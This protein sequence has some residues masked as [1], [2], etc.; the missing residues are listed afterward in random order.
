MGACAGKSSRSAVVTVK[1]RPN[2]VNPSLAEHQAAFEEY[3]DH[4]KNIQEN[5]PI[6]QQQPQNPQPQAQSI[7][8]QPNYSP[9][10]DD[11]PQHISQEKQV[12][13]PTRHTE[14]HER[15]PGIEDVNEDDFAS[16][17]NK[18]ESPQAQNKAKVV[19][20]Y[21]Q[22][23][24]NFALNFPGNQVHQEYRET[25]HNEETKTYES[26]NKDKKMR[27]IINNPDDLEHSMSSPIKKSA[28][29]KKND[30]DDFD[31]F[32]NNDKPTQNIE[33]HH[34][35]SNLSN[36]SYGVV[37]EQ[38]NKG[39]THKIESAS[40]MSGL[41]TNSIAKNEKPVEIHSPERIENHVESPVK[42]EEIVKEESPVKMRESM[43]KKTESPEKV[44]MM[45]KS[46]EKMPWERNSVVKEDENEIEYFDDELEGSKG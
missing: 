38:N 9:A 7:D 33:H 16:Q 5:R 10:E 1:S 42:R 20:V 35:Q 25:V 37:N 4:P 30:D 12:I 22:E 14:Q 44:P 29:I 21:T 26:K 36:G 11:Q 15:S 32:I 24:D 17:F 39:T 8:P 13:S 45:R 40:P 28:G 46:L 43:E 3:D 31:A 18:K 19:P 6:S 41:L 2:K 27:D 34:R 23:N